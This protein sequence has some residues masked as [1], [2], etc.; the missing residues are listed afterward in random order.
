M[1]DDSPRDRVVGLR[2]LAATAALTGRETVAPAE[3]HPDAELLN[4]CATYLDLCADANAIDREA[5]KQPGQHVGNPQFDAARVRSREKE[6]EAKRILNRLGKMRAATA[7]GV[8][9]K[10]TIV[11]TR[12]GYMSAPNFM[13]S[14]A[15]DLVNCPGLRAAVWPAGEG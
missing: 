3:P 2:L 7:A 9:A 1:S 4:A 8:Y 11:V 6:A 14:L 13:L 15:D 12:R 10:A 5:R